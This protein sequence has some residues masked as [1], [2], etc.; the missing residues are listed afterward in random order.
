[1]KCPKCSKELANDSIFCEYCGAQVRKQKKSRKT[2][3][4]VLTIVFG[5]LVLCCVGG[6]GWLIQQDNE[7]M[8]KLNDIHSIYSYKS[9]TSTNKN[10][11]SVSSKEYTLA[12]ES[13]DEIEITYKVSSEP[14]YDVFTITLIYPSGRE[15]VLCNASGQESK[16]IRKTVFSTGMYTLKVQY[17]KDGN[18][19]KNSD[20]GS[21][22]S[23]KIHKTKIK[24]L[25]SQF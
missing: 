17:K 13:D 2:P 12:L 7:R 15:D 21:I 16:K 8:E 5:V 9:W 6:L 18:V 11:N 22:T 3:W 4:V 10:A 19:N 25:Q 1:M 23:L 14:I 24:Q 20:N